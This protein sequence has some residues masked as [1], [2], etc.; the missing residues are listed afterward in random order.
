MSDKLRVVVADD[1]LMAR[2]RLLRLLQAIP[3]V[4]V[5]GECLNGPEVLRRIQGNDVDVLLLDIRMP[6]LSGLEAMRQMPPDGPYVIFCTA[7][8][9]HAVQAFDVGAVDY[10]LKPVEAARLVKALERARSR[11]R[12]GRF[13]KQL[14]KQSD[15]AGLGP[16]LPRLPIDTRQGIV[17]LDPRQISHAQ[18]DGELVKVATRD[19]EH[20]TDSSLQDLE[21]K[22]PSSFMR[23]HRR[24]LVNLEQ[25]VRL[26][27]CETGGFLARM[28][29][30]DR[31]QVSRQAARQLRRMLGLRGVPGGESAPE[32]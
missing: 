19:G 23:V 10:L 27:P 15:A 24:A 3:D 14:A 12:A 13:R 2:R 18:L 30:G 8:S 29:C 7:H 31:I 32:D 22:L 5:C 21:A 25:I 1:E 26:E 9:E 17:L 28:A 4:E 11:E 6:G 20:L 16:D